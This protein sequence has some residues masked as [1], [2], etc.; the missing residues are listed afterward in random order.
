[1]QPSWQILIMANLHLKKG[2]N[3]RGRDMLPVVA[4]LSSLSLEAWTDKASMDQNTSTVPFA[5]FSEKHLLTSD[6]QEELAQE[7]KR[8]TG[9]EILVSFYAI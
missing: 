7:F 3:L 9:Y 2:H 8:M 4:R 5:S 1:M 6:S